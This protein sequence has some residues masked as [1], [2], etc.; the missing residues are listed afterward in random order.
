V[1]VHADR[2]FPYPLGV[3]LRGGRANVAVYSSSADSIEFCVFAEGVDERR[4][5]LTDRTG[6]VFHGLVPDVGPGTK[7]ALRL[8]GPWNPAAG[9]RHNPHKLLLDPHARAVC[10][11]YTWGQAVFGHDLNDPEKMDATDGAGSTPLS[12]ITADDFDW[13]DD[14]HPL[15][16]LAETIV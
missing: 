15:T 13:G 2:S 7:Y 10:G 11:D 4:V 12:V 5:Q 16:P 9:L 14:A 1:T 3:S 8:D 6:H